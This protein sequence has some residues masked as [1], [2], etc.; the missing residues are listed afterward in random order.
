MKENF[1]KLIMDFC[2]AVQLPEPVKIMDGAP[3]ETNGVT[4]ALRHEKAKPESVLVFTDFGPMPAKRKKLIY[5]TLLEENFITAIG[6]TGTFGMSSAT[7]NI[8]YIE[9]LD[10]SA[11]TVER[12]YEKLVQLA[13][14]ANDWRVTHYIGDEPPPPPRTRGSA[15]FHPAVAGE[16]KAGS[17]QTQRS[18]HV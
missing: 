4:F 8:V 18:N 1:E 14:Q 17:K 6:S 9:Q 5:Y 10:I 7:R 13:A 15:S 2:A 3:F 11:M 16:R 12:L